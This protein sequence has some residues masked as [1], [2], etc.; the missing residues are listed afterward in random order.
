MTNDE[1]VRSSHRSRDRGIFRIAACVA[2]CGLLC[3]AC[4]E[5]SPTKK[6][7]DRGH[8]AS[9]DADTPPGDGNPIEPREVGDAAVPVR[10]EPDVATVRDAN[11]VKYSI[12]RVLRGP[13]TTTGLIIPYLHKRSLAMAEADLTTLADETLKQLAS[14]VVQDRFFGPQVHVLDG[15]FSMLGVIGELVAHRSIPPQTIRAWT[16]PALASHRKDDRTLTIFR[17]R[18]ADIV[19]A[20]KDR[21]LADLLM[22]FFKNDSNDRGIAPRCLAALLAFGS[23]WAERAMQETYAS[24]GPLVWKHA[25]RLATTTAGPLIDYSTIDRVAWWTHLIE[26]SAPPLTRELPQFKRFAWNQVSAWT[27]PRVWRIPQEGFSERNVPTP[28]VPRNNSGWQSRP[29]SKTAS[30]PLHSLLLSGKGPAAEARCALATLEHDYPVYRTSLNADL[31]LKGIDDLLYFRALHCTMDQAVRGDTP[32]ADPVAQLKSAVGPER[33][34][35]SQTPK[36][37]IEMIQ[38]VPNPATDA[39]SKKVLFNILQDLRPLSI[40]GPA[41]RAAYDRLEPVAPE[42]DARLKQMLLGDDATQY[43]KRSALHAIRRELRPRYASMLLAYHDRLP[44]EQQPSIRRLLIPMIAKR[45]GIEPKL[46]DEF[47]NRLVAW[48]DAMPLDAISRSASSLLDFGERGSN[49]FVRGLLGPK[50]K[51]YIGAWPQHGRHPVSL[52]LAR[53]LI[54]PIDAKTPHQEVSFALT[55]AYLTFPPTA[56]PGIAGLG[57]RVGEAHEEAIETVLQRVRHRALP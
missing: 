23:P 6:N 43:S 27:D 13:G 52:T 34:Q 30:I 2:L 48:I 3:S 25:A 8:T 17:R 31:S 37:V 16:E 32:D 57:E 53:A 51:A 4:G 44:P 29:Y 5:S 7:D 39:R 15:W 54:N 28:P 50:R 18:A 24:G 10:D 11:K 20:T 45:R 35:F 46:Y 12:E 1:P 42:R 41:V 40:W 55:L 22:E 36:V 26:T 21:S 9:K 38:A 19:A 56:A 47:T 49:A 14:P 33:E